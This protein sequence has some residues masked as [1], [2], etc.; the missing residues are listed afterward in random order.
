MWWGGNNQAFSEEVNANNQYLKPYSLCTGKT[1]HFIDDCT[2]HIFFL[3]SFSLADDTFT[4]FRNQHVSNGTSETITSRWTRNSTNEAIFQK[5]TSTG[6]RGRSI[7]GC[8]MTMVTDDYLLSSDN[9]LSTLSWSYW[10]YVS[11]THG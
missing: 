2:Q 5:T 4:H 8:G 9:G 7:L 11:K 1:L 3:S 10:F 6:R